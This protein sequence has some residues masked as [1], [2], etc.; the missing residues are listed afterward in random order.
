M[1]ND[2]R[3]KIN[4][5]INVIT[6]KII[7]R[8]FDDAPPTYEMQDAM[9]AAVHAMNMMAYDTGRNMKREVA[10]L[11]YHL[12]QPTACLVRDRYTMKAMSLAVTALKYQM[13]SETGNF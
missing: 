7:D 10:I 12:R 5:A 13:G 9:T 4:K 2:E 6:Y 8:P 11:E 3:L 1:T